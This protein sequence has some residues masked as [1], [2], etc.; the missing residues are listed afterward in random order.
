LKVFGITGLLGVLIEW[1]TKG[2]WVVRVK[3]NIPQ[4]EI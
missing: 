1:L 3:H 4:F 2:R